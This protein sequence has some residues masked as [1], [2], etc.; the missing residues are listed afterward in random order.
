MGIAKLRF[1]TEALFII[2][3]TRKVRKTPIKKQRS[4]TEPQ[5]RLRQRILRL[6]RRKRQR[7]QQKQIRQLLRQKSSLQKSSLQKNSRQKS[8]IRRSRSPILRRQLRRKKRKRSLRLMKRVQRMLKCLRRTLRITVRNC[9]SSLRLIREEVPPTLFY[10]SPAVLQRRDSCYEA[11][12]IKEEFCHE[13]YS[14]NVLFYFSYH[15]FSICVP[16][17]AA[18]RH[19]ESEFRRIGR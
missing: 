12:I 5:R 2:S 6:W 3:R 15:N 9:S 14:D 4:R 11:K 8:R 17:P 16:Y 10:R 19:R 18:G 13:R 7:R 1:W